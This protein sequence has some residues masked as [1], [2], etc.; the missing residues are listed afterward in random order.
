MIDCLF[1]LFFGRFFSVFVVMIH[2]LSRNKYQEIELFG[3]SL[4]CPRLMSS[5]GIDTGLCPDNITIRPTERALFIL[6]VF[7]WILYLCLVFLWILYLFL[8]FLLFI[9]IFW[10]SWLFERFCSFL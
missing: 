4:G 2:R 7:Y 6:F 5:P 1:I 10:V 9:F 8:L 3:Q